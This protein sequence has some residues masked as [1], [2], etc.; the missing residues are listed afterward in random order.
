MKRIEIGVHKAQP[1][2]FKTFIPHPFPLMEGFDFDQKIL[3][4]NNAGIRPGGRLTFFA[5]TKKVS[6]EV[7]PRRALFGFWFGNHVNSF[8]I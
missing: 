3:K 5:C 4:Q 2:G 7:H 1:T 8:S 6:K